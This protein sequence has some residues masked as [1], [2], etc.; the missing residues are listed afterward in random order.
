MPIHQV[1]VVLVRQRVDV[2]TDVDVRHRRPA[3]AGRIAGSTLRQPVR[4]TVGAAHRQPAC[5]RRRPPRRRPG[6]D[7]IS[8]SAIARRKS[9]LGSEQK[10]MPARASAQ[11]G[12]RA[13]ATNGRAVRRGSRGGQPPPMTCPGGRRRTPSV[14]VRS[15]RWWWCILR[16]RPAFRAGVPFDNGLIPGSPPD[17]DDVVTLDVDEESSIGRA[18]DGRNA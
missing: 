17:P 1:D 14:G 13:R 9:K 12:S 6:S 11:S 5:R 2:W 8:T 16:Q 4:L 15:G 7:W 10:H 3:T 18:D